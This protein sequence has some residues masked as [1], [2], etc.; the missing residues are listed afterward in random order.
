[1][2]FSEVGH[3]VIWSNQDDLLNEFRWSHLF[4]ELRKRLHSGL[5]TPVKT[6][7]ETPVGSKSTRRFFE[8]KLKRL[9]SLRREPFGE[10][11]SLITNLQLDQSL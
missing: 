7:V 6:P 5:G 4:G 11:S 9:L 8:A 10:D 3:N 2:C 1:M